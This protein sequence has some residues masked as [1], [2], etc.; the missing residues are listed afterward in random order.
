MK[1]ITVW[2]SYCEGCCE[3]ARLVERAGI[4]NVF[5]RVLSRQIALLQQ[6]PHD[7]VES[8]LDVLDIARASHAVRDNR[9]PGKKKGLEMVVKNGCENDGEGLHAAGWRRG[10][11]KWI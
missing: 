2:R 3:H 8:V 1:Q 10:D 9:E 4:K 11:F 7:E 5:W 6:P